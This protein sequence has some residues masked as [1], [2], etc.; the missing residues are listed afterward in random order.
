[1]LYN[2]QYNINIIYIYIYIY[3]LSFR[4]YLHFNT[5]EFTYYQINIK[6]NL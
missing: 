5:I 3:I 1:M 6:T 2:A 4:Y